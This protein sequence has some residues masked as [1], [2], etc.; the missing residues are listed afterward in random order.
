MDTYK[1]ER[2]TMSAL[3]FRI[4]SD[5]IETYEQIY[6]RVLDSP[7]RYSEVQFEGDDATKKT[8]KFKQCLRVHMFLV[9]HEQPKILEFL[10]ENN[11]GLLLKTVI[12]IDDKLLHGRGRLLSSS[13]S[14][15]MKKK[16]RRSSHC[17]ASKYSTYLK[18]CW[19]LL[20]HHDTSSEKK[21]KAEVKPEKNEALKLLDVLCRLMAACAADEEENVDTLFVSEDLSWRKVLKQSYAGKALP[22]LDK[23]MG[24]NIVVKREIA[25]MVKDL[26]ENV[27]LIFG[28]KERTDDER[29][30]AK[31]AFN[32][33]REQ[34]K[35][36]MH[37]C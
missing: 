8:K 37:K 4:P 30:T 29:T 7:S 27:H 28:N 5:E 36:K 15:L 6:A 33:I 20:S 35:K 10:V 25:G 14:S 26:R 22:M 3:G 13:S 21:K 17:S 19:L 18:L 24:G 32:L 9:A 12:E 1:R 23:M 34:I 31:I 16:Y 2:E 11:P